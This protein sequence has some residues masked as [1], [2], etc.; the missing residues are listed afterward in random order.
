MHLRSRRAPDLQAM[1]L[2]L[3]LGE[4]LDVVDAEA[5]MV[6]R[7]FVPPSFSEIRRVLNT[8]V[9]RAVALRRGPRRPGPDPVAPLPAQIIALVG[10]LELVTFDADETIYPDGS[11]LSEDSPACAFIPEL[12]KRGYRV[13]LCTAAGYKD[14]T[15]YETRL[16]GVRPGR[17]AC[18]APRAQCC[19][20][21]YCP[22][23]HP[24]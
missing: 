6:A 4:A 11:V 10:S 9:V 1:Y 14:A 2:E 12:L 17:L 7:R 24:R 3:P 23:W 13:A 5:G 8:A 22:R 15:K 16:R 20:C 18:C 21:H 19:R